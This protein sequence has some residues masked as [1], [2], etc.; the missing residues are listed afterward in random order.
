VGDVA[1]RVPKRLSSWKAIGLIAGVLALLLLTYGLYIHAIA[2]RRWRDMQ[3]SLQELRSMSDLRNG[4]RPVLRGTAVPGN[5]WEDYSPALTIMK[6]APTS[7]LR[8]SVDRTPKADR[9]KLEAALATHGKALDGLRKGAMR[10]D[11]IY[12]LKWEEGFSADI[13]GLL[14]SQNLTNLA[15]CRSR[16]LIEEGKSREAAELLLDTCQFAHDLGY[17]QMLISEMISLALYGI[18]LEEL[19]DLVLHGNLSGADLAEI[20]RELEILDRSFPKNG[21][22]MLNE[23]MLAGY[24]FL[25]ADGSP[26]ELYSG[27]DGSLEWDYFV[28]RSLLPQRLIGADAFFTELDYM[29]RFAEADEQS[30]GTSQAVVLKSQAEMVKLKNP[31]SRVLLPGLTSSS[32]AGRD[33]RTQL[34]LLRIAAQ[35]RATGE[36]LELEDPFGAK[37][38]SSV[39][40]GT[41]K[42]WSVGKD[43]VDDG[44]KGQWKPDRGPDIVL[45]VDK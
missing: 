4:P 33:R 6:S 3:Q 10:A 40:G 41:L 28:W 34:R 25:K 5:A 38:L 24:H 45:D 42:V 27:V 20:A 12:R 26:R 37:L 18:A 35:Y 17:N 31:V 14:Q 29:K 36:I 44:G 11:G 39:Y 15:V 19:R 16:L 43:G 13:P 2:D 22:S 7:V 23:A 30:W 32:Q 1:S 21:D 8:E 9:A